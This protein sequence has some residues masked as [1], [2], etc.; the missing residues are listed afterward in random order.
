MVARHWQNRML[1]GSSDT[2]LERLRRSFAVPDLSLDVHTLAQLFRVETVTVTVLRPPQFEDFPD[3][4]L[5][6][7]GALGN[8]LHMLGPP[9]Q[10]RPTS[11]RRPKAWDVLQTELLPGMPKP[12]VLQVDVRLGQI[13][14]HAH[15]IGHA[16][17]WLPDVEAAL[18]NACDGGVSLS[19]E[20]RVKAVLEVV[21]VTR[22][23]FPG[24]LPPEAAITQCRLKFMTPLRLRSGIATK[25][26]LPALIISLASRVWQYGKDMPCRWIGASCT[27]RHGN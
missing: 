15:L 12:L 9:P 6:I 25:L 14:I 7:R 20:S 18:V 3:L 24:F 19:N 2:F 23:I 10:M 4:V 5:R 11:T 26:S 27:S 17:F 8:S 16:T 13:H 1:T 21:D 22:T